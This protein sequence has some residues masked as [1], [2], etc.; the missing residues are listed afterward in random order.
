MKRNKLLFFFFLALVSTLTYWGCS[1]PEDV[2]TP[3]SQTKM[4]LHEERLPTTPPN[5][6]YELWLGNI[7]QTDT[8]IIKDAVSLG[9]FKYDFDR[10]TFETEAGA[11]RPDSSEFH[12]NHDILSYN[13]IFMTVEAMNDPEPAVPG[14]VMLISSATIPT[15]RM[16]FPKS[17]SLWG[18][19]V[20]YNMQSPSNGSSL[21]DAGNAIW[22][23]LYN[24]KVEPFDD[25]VGISSWSIDTTDS[26]VLP[27]VPD[28]VLLGIDSADI[29]VET[30]QVVKGLDT[31]PHIVTTY[32]IMDT[33]IDQDL[34]Y[35]TKL[36]V[37][38][39]TIPRPAIQWDDF[40]QGEN[41]ADF[42]FPIIKDWGWKYKGWVVA[43]EIPTSAVG[44][45]TKPAWLLQNLYLTQTDGGLISTGT[46][47]DIRK[48]D[49]A[50]PY[51]ASTRVPPYPGEDFLQ[52][53][54]PGVPTPLDLVPNAS[55]GNPG[56]VFI[57]LE[58]INAQTDTTNFPLV[59][60]I[61]PLP[62]SY[63]MVQDS[64][65]Q[66]FTLRGWMQT[67]DTYRGFPAITVETQRY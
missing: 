20:W 10:R 58:P 14:P 31:L 49:S 8:V 32:S 38:Y 46:F 9:R 21:S 50:N 24:Y 33:I 27:G 35:I 63:H 4:W 16:T 2:L 53:L 28:T 25:T 47:Y 44:Q 62:S 12:I 60:F 52:N 59:L 37:N 11:D 45:M 40:S 48:P 6:V 61:G 43:P 66:Q 29:K 42:G 17:D 5:M 41:N 39:D 34:H 54:P 18:S 23:S 56:R 36:V 65:T 19:T 57:S 51:S 26:E 55:G 3:V 15:I 22:F 1:Q 13:S 67:D 30:L 64:T 7:T